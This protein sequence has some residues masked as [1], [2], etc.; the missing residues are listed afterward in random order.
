MWPGKRGW[1]E[2]ALLV[3]LRNCRRTG[4]TA[5]ESANHW[6]GLWLRPHYGLN[7][8]PAKIPKLRS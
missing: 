7:Y 2:Q 4:P 8:V 6:L 3:G 5:G 1:E